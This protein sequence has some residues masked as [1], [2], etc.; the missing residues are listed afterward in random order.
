MPIWRVTLKMSRFCPKGSVASS[1]SLGK[2]LPRYMDKAGKKFA[3]LGGGTEA[4][5]LLPDDESGKIYT[6]GFLGDSSSPGS[7]ERDK[8]LEWCRRIAKQWDKLLQ[9]RSGRRSDGFR[10]VL[11]LGPR[12]ADDLKVNGISTDMAL[13]NIWQQTMALY[14]QRHGWNNC[15]GELAWLCGGH[16]DA[17]LH[18]ILFPTTRSGSGGGYFSVK[19][20]E[21]SSAG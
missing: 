10:W 6:G 13:R 14:Q 20:L 12:A 5:C 17:R 1:N 9:P 15:K 8:Q 16:H 18:I 3:S 11:S 2:H 4:R 19:M 21:K 7:A